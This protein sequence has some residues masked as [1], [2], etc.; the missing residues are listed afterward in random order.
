MG[1]VAWLAP[2]KPQGSEANSKVAKGRQVRR[3]LA[4]T[5][6]SHLTLEV[7]LRA[8]FQP[9]TEEAWVL[10]IRLLS[11]GCLPLRHVSEALQASVALALK[12][13]S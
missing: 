1:K 5:L 3:R 2:W 6:F 10:D 11:N 7:R 8:R 12:W 4:R 9:R 13:G